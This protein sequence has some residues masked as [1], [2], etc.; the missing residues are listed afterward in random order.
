MRIGALAT[1]QAIKDS[2]LIAQKFPPIWQAASKVGTLQICNLGTLGGNLANASPSAEF[3][4]P[5]LTLGASVQC[6]GTGGD[7][8]IPIEEFFVGPG[9]SVLRDDEMITE[10][11]V[12]NLPSNARGIYL[13]HSLRHMDVAIASAAVVVRL[14]GGVFED[15]KIALGAVAPTPIRARKA[16]AA[17]LRQRLDGAGNNGELLEEIARVAS[18]E[19]LPIDDLRAYARYRRHVVGMLVRQG[20][21]ESIA[22]LKPRARGGR[23]NEA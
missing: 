11:L 19:S 13:K 3:A 6:A 23:S 22:Q 15:I 10:V 4:P 5:L 2:A 20:L 17:L 9:K 12:P 14:H 18:S 1:I 16:E 8:L 21:E 7:R